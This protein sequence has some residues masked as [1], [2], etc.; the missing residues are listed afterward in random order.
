VMEYV[1]NG[2]CQS[3]AGVPQAL[4][5]ADTDLGILDE[6]L[7]TLGVTWRM[8]RRLGL[9]YNEELD[10]YEKEVGKAMAVDGGA[11]IL[12]IVPSTYSFLLSPA[13]IQESS[14]P[15]PGS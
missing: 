7:M 10:E 3:E 5:E 6:N 15:G 4:W 13:N 11:A 14:F 1:S 8:L 2:W 9:S 12:S